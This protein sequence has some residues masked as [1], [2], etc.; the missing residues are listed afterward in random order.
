MT[1]HESL[2]A[3]LARIAIKPRLFEACDY[4]NGDVPYQTLGL[5]GVE[6]P[7]SDGMGSGS[8]VTFI[9]EPDGQLRKVSAYK[10]SLDGH[11]GP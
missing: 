10:S 5:L 1:D 11:F 9:F 6:F 8:W 4:R 3:M 2:L 7:T